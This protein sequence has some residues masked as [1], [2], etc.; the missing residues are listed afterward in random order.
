MRG[1]LQ[2]KQLRDPAAEHRAPKRLRVCRLPL[3]RA[4]ALLTG[5]V[6]RG[7]AW[8]CG[9]KRRGPR[10]IPPLRGGTNARATRPMG[11]RRNRR[12]GREPLVAGRTS[13]LLPIYGWGASRAI[14]RSARALAS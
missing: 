2:G 8:A 10:D 1:P 7:N 3:K 4:D 11:A 5:A 12:E 13:D 9:S 6:L 14:A